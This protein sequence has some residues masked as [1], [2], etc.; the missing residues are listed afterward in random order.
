MRKNIML[1]II[2]IIIITISIIYN[3]FPRLQLNGKKNITISYNDTYEEQGVIVK[4]ATG[5][6]M[7]KI[8]IENNIIKNKIGT[9]HVDYSLKLKG[10]KLHVRRTVKIIDNIAPKIELYGPSTIELKINEKYIEKGY[11]AIDEYD[12]DITEKVKII[13]EI[14]NNKPGQYILT[15]KVKDTSNN[16]TQINRTI[17][18]NEN[19]QK[20]ISNN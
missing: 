14:D 7:S 20:E 10:R 9:Y 6:Y 3:V 4:N 15:Y 17:K 2:I 12:G 13:G 8:K 5:N 1:I 11:K 16:E 19:K 18:I